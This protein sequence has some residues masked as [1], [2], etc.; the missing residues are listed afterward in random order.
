MLQL[1]L[2]TQGITLMT[3]LPKNENGFSAV[4][5]LLVLL[6]LIVIGGAGYFVAKHVD[7]KTPTTATTVSTTTTT[8]ATTSPTIPKPAQPVNP[9]AGWSTYSSTNE[10]LSFKYPVNWT[11]QNDPCVNPDTQVNGQCY[12]FL[13]PKTASSSYIFEV[14]YYWNQQAASALKSGE[15]IKSVTPLNVSG[16]KTPLSL[17]SYS[18]NQTSSSNVFGLALT[19]Q[20]YTVGQTVSFIPNITSQ[21]QSGMTYTLTAT[22][23]TPS[24]QDIANY[25]LAQY[26]AQPDYSNVVKMF[27]S[28]SY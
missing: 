17:V 24:Q 12:Q 10:G 7:K 13:T 28:L 2:L 19:D 16:T 1:S 6:T 9:Y 23:K 3:K 11:A 20:V 4:E 5:L 21:K 25:S 26:Q 22:M 18:I 14:T 8:S 27:Q 15:T